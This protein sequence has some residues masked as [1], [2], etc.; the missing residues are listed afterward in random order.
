[1]WNDQGEFFV[2]EADE[3]DGTFLKVGAATAIV[4]N[5]E[6]DHLDYFGTYEALV[7]AFTDF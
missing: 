6:S 7:H 3:S 4:T 2:V 1:M 5:L